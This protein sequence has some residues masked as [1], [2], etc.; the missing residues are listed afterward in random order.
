MEAP[1]TTH[2]RFGIFLRVSG[3]GPE[4]RSLRCMSVEP[5]SRM[6]TVHTSPTTH[7]ILP[8]KGKG[9]SD[10]GYSWVPVVGPIVGAIVGTVLYYV[11][12]A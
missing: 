8:I 12:L 5:S 4:A 9:G 1:E 6:R 3:V 11:T 10:W 2:R 7:A